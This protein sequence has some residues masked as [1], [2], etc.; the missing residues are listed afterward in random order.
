MISPGEEVGYIVA[1]LIFCCSSAA[2]PTASHS[3]GDWPLSSI[4]CVGVALRAGVIEPL[5]VAE[6]VRQ[7]V[8]EIGHFRPTGTLCGVVGSIVK[9]KLTSLSS[10]SASRMVP[11]CESPSSTKST[12]VIAVAAVE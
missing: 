5:Q 4:S 11:A 12:V 9:M 2:A 7:R 10:M 8:L 1:I 3:G 6:L